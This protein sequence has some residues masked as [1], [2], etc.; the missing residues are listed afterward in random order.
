MSLNVI[1]WCYIPSVGVMDAAS[2]QRG[3]CQAGQMPAV[4]RFAPAR[5]GWLGHAD[6]SPLSGPGHKPQLLLLGPHGSAQLEL[7]AA[8]SYS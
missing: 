7:V 8:K 1:T 6:P 5:S 4:L 3:M 2:H